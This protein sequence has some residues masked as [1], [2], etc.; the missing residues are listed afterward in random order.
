M[1]KSL[2]QSTLRL[3]S[4]FFLILSGQ[5]VS[6]PGTQVTVLA[7]PLTTITLNKAAPLNTSILIACGRAPYFLLGI[8]TGVP[9]DKV[10]HI[11]LLLTTNLLMSVTIFTLSLL[12]FNSGYISM[13]HLYTVALTMGVAAM[14]ADITFLTLIP[15][16]VPCYLL[17]QAQNQV[18]LLQ[19]IATMVGL[20]LAGWMIAILTSP[21]A[22]LADALSFL[23]VVALIPF[24]SNSKKTAIISEPKPE[25]NAI[26]HTKLTH[27]SLREFFKSSP[28]YE[29]SFHLFARCAH[30]SC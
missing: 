27:N 7:I 26:K 9:V 18:E 28:L 25:D 10:P 14:V 16:L 13:V 21:V 15:T 12:Y 11:K 6:L 4:S 1:M 2:P 17:T 19:S 20:P 22:V 30:H 24:V 29:S 8:F 23:L 3:P 5:F